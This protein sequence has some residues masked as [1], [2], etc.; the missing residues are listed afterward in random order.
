MAISYFNI[1]PEILQ[2]QHHH[3]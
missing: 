2:N 1:L 3:W